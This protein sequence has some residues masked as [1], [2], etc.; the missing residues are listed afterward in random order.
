M[1]VVGLKESILANVA[2]EQRE[3]IEARMEQPEVKETFEK[4]EELS[5]NQEFVFSLMGAKNGDELLK[6]AGEFGLQIDKESAD[7]AYELIHTKG[8]EELTESDLDQVAGGCPAVLI[9][10]GVAILV[11]VG[12]GTYLALRWAKKKIE[13]QGIG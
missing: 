2:P 8:D 6:T 3:E 7:A 13:E 5:T 12:V 1:G 10:L 11:G 9:G 4:L